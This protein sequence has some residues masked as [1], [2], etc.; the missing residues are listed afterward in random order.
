MKKIIY[1]LIMILALVMAHPSQAKTNYKIS[2]VVNINTATK[3]ELVMIP[4]IGETK[5]EAIM[6]QRSQK[7]FAS[8]EDL[9]AIKGIGEKILGKISPYLVVNGTT[10]IQKVKVASDSSQKNKSIN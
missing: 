7:P 10:N 4:G 3:T 2:G 5:A 1:M 9:L 8:K 6:Q